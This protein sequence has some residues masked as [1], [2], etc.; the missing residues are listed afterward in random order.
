MLSNILLLLVPDLFFCGFLCS[1]ADTHHHSK[2]EQ[3]EDDREIQ[4]MHVFD[5]IRPGVCLI[6][7]W[8]RV[9]EIQNH[10]QNADQHSQ[11]QTPERSLNHAQCKR[12]TCKRSMK[13][14]HV[15]SV[16]FCSI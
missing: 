3:G 9:D 7:L 1:Q 11:H 16:L 6:A 12:Q 2:C 15:F 14:T 10:P 13:T 8:Y 4:I 5:N